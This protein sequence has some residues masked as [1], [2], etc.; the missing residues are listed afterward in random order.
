MFKVNSSTI[1]M[2]YESY[3]HHHHHQ[4]QQQQQ[5]RNLG[6]SKVPTNKWSP[7]STQPFKY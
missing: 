6:S 4:Q 1:Q 7:N 2:T 3:D 5:L